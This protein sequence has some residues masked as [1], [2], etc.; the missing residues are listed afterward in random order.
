[1]KLPPV[2]NPEVV[3]MVKVAFCAP[4]VPVG[5]K[6]TWPVVQVLPALIARFAVQVP[7]DNSQNAP[8]LEV[9]G[10][11]PKVIGPPLAVIVT[12]PQVLET[13]MP[14]LPQATVEG[15]AEA[16]PKTLVPERL[17]LVPVP[18]LAATVTVSVKMP[19]AE[20]GLKRMVLTVQEAPEASTKLGAQVPNGVVKSVPSVVVKK[21]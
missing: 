6:L 21:V 2:P 18:K 4:P 9:M 1:M 12:V 16:V 5:S 8:L 20:V 10:V 11:A 3:A 13:P 19:V 14:L 15:A 17:K 7:F